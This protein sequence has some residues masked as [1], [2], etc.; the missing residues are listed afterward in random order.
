MRGKTSMAGERKMEWI[1][2][3]VICYWQGLIN[4]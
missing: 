4:F 2:L 1:M 3:P